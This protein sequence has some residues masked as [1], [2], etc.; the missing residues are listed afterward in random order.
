MAA[1]QDLDSALS[2]A[3][4]R[5]G[6]QAM[7]LKPQQRESVKC[8]YEGKDVFLWLPTGFGKSICYEVL[9]FVFDVKLARVDSVVIVVSPLVSLMTDQTRSLRSR[10]VKAAIMSSMG[11]VEKD[12]LA[13]ADDLERSSFCFVLPR[14]L[15]VAG[16]EN[17]LR[18]PNYQTEL[19]QWPLMRLTVCR[20]GTL[21]AWSNIIEVSI[22][23]V[24]T[25]FCGGVLY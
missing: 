2:Y 17:L 8:M 1:I 14:R 18:S 16:G 20:S 24:F 21:K 4:Q 7:M 12:L 5:L 15:C 10:G 13:T 19:L 6:C 3:L 25:L 11:G 9:P 23:R 22:F